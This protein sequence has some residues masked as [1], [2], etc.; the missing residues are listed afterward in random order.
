MADKIMF[1]NKINTS[2]QIGDELW[3]SNIV[4]QAPTTPLFSSGTITD[5][6][7][8]WV[9][10]DAAPFS[11]GSGNFLINP[12]FQISLGNEEAT[13]GTFDTDLSGWDSIVSDIIWEQD[14]NGN[15]YM[16]FDNAT[17]SN[18]NAATQNIDNLTPNSQYQISFDYE[19]ISGALEFK[20]QVTG[21]ANMQQ[22]YFT[23]VETGT[24]TTTFNTDQDANIYI[25]FEE[26][27]NSTVE[28]IIDNFSVKEISL[29]GWDTGDGWTI[30]GEQAEHT[31]TGG[32]LDGSLTSNFVEGE[33]YK[34]EMDVISNNGDIILAN[35][36]PY[37][38]GT[39]YANVT[40]NID[41][42]VIPNKG[43]AEWTQNSINLDKIRIFKGNNKNCVIDNISI[44]DPSTFEELFF[45]FK[46]PSDQNIA[47]LNG[48]YAE[49]TLTNNSSE[50]RELFMIGSE[51]TMSSK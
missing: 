34:I 41:T 48:Y 2:V 40:V 51:I 17:S 9:Q 35:V 47:S 3:Y 46:K 45:M 18:Y 32:F 16:Y 28:A 27:N 23:T 42:S 26:G 33:T 30:N 22:N 37:T 7:D 11:T 39:G 15:G 4:N 19:I 50:K 20:A 1:K 21:G 29:Q 24:Y 25:K 44:I 6:G 31:G 12:S 8:N 43:T 36:G 14:I 5:I 49:A 38:Y 10:V 13:N